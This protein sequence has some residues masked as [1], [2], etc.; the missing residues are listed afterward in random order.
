[1]GQ[2]NPCVAAPADLATR[3]EVTRSWPIVTFCH[4][5]A[6]LARYIMNLMPS[7]SR[8]PVMAL[9]LKVAV[10]HLMA[11]ASQP[12]NASRAQDILTRA[13]DLLGASCLRGRRS[14]TFGRGGTSS[15]RRSVHEDTDGFHVRALPD[16][17]RDGGL[18]GSDCT[19]WQSPP[20][21]V[22]QRLRT[23]SSCTNAAAGV[24]TQGSSTHHLVA[25]FRRWRLPGRRPA[26][27]SVLLPSRRCRLPMSRSQT[28]GP[29]L[30]SVTRLSTAPAPCAQCDRRAMGACTTDATARSI[31]RTCVE[32]IVRPAPAASA[33]ARGQHEPA[34]PKFVCPVEH[35]SRTRFWVPSTGYR[36]A[37]YA[38]DTRRRPHR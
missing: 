11:K 38:T 28:V 14:S 37:H 30:L 25:R 26:F 24:T 27:P 17:P 33:Q 5:V 23:H 19:L 21:Q 7:L 8:L 16:R 1:M 4:S 22:E 3:E 2:R 20:P 15:T 10:F 32:F 35:P 29:A 9:R 31:A 18:R 12:S 36:P 6:V 13:S 34:W